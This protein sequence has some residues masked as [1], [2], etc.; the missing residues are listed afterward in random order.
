[1]T[2]LALS[3]EITDKGSVSALLL[4][5]AGARLLYVLGHGAGAGMRHRFMD[6][7]ATHLFHQGIATFRYQ[8]P[9]MEAGRRSPDSPSVLAAT[10]RAAV[11]A[12][13]DAAQD[14]P[15][16]AGGKSLGGRISSHV[17][18][19]DAPVVIKGLI[20]LGYPLHAP[21]KPNVK[22]SEHLSS[23][24]V[25]MLFLQGTR[26]D[27]ADLE[28]FEPIIN[29]LGPIA[30][31]HKVQGGDHSFNVLKRSGRNEHEVMQEL[32]EAISTWTRRAL[33]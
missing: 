17:V 28:L 31:L 10:V 12:A 13:H 7:V 32:A 14:L 27:L 16:L 33:S 21:R 19:S 5:P 25:P 30:T 18:A 6:S 15:I 20:F 24:R 26:D 3:F 23:I 1:M 2:E 22:R 11:A 8:F 9:Y 29:Q 4:R